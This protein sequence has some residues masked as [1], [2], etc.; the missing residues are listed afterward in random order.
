M[1]VELS[2]RFIHFNVKSC[3]VEEDLCAYGMRTFMAGLVLIS[4]SYSFTRGLTLDGIP[5][6]MSVPGT[7]L[8]SSEGVPIGVS[9][10][11]LSGLESQCCKAIATP[12]CRNADEVNGWGG[13]RE[14]A[15]KPISPLS[16]FYEPYSQWRTYFLNKWL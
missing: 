1:S 14:A 16:Q 2:T 8:W 5:M 11:P 3:W 7:I 6:S 10:F 13:G 9:Y 15:V 12:N 4:F